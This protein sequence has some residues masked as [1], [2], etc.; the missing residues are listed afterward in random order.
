GILYTH[1]GDDRGFGPEHDLARDNIASEFE[2]YGLVVTLEPFSYWGTTYYNVVGTKLGTTYPGQEYIIGAHYD[3]VDNP[4]ADDNASGVALVLEAARIICQYDSGCTIRFIAFDREE[5]GMIGSQAYVDA[6]ISDDILGMI[7]AD[8]VSY[9]NGGNVADIN[10]RSASNPIKY[11]LGDAVTEYG[12]GLTYAIG[13]AAD[14]SDHAPFEWVGFQ[15]CI[16][17]ED[18]G[19]PYYHTP[20]DN[21]DMPGYIDYAYA[22]RMTRSVVGFLVDQ[23]GVLVFDCYGDLDGDGDVDLSDLAQLLANYGT[24]EGATYADGDL[25]GDGDV[26]LADLAELLAVYG[27]TCS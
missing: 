6:H 23:A 9:N 10:G 18:W 1:V 7:S 19:N 15:A 27:T 8:M 22:I 14:Y 20:N 11:A 25:D 16:L 13:G 12:D 5:Q 2:T 4:G 24:S 21:V 17:I 26:D 3:S